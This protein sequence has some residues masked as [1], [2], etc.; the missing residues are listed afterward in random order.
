MINLA[1]KKNPLF[2]Q[3]PEFSPFV[4]NWPCSPKHKDPQKLLYDVTSKCKAKKK[5]DFIRTQGFRTQRG[6]QEPGMWSVHM[7]I[8]R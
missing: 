4:L 7:G 2:L 5:G 6:L 8:V 1:N 3:H